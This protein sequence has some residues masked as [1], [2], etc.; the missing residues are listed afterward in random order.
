FAGP[1]VAAELRDLAADREGGVE[2]ELREDVRDEPGR[3]RL[4]VRTGDDD[5]V[6]QRDELREEIGARPPRDA[7]VRARDDDFP[8]VANDRLHRRPR[9]PGAGPRGRAPPPAPPGPGPP[10]RPPPPP[11]P[12]PAGATA[13]SAESPAPPMP[14]NQ[15]RRPSRGR[16]KL[17]Q[18]LGDPARRVR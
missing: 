15:I 4:A 8:A 18:L 12:P 3:R 13:A 7:R 2:P 9:P 11:P 16:C 5:R 14:T 10:P 1:R 17:D 6:A